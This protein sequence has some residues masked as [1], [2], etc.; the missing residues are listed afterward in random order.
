MLA[1]HLIHAMQPDEAVLKAG[2]HKY[3]TDPA[4]LIAA[5]HVVAVEFA[6]IAMANNYWRA[7]ATH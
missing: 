2:R 7:T 5:A 3:S 6:T 1:R 4:E